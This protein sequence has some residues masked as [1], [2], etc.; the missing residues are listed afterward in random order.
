NQVEVTLTAEH[1]VITLYEQDPNGGLTYTV[2]DGTED[3]AMT[4]S[5]KLSDINRA[6]QWVIF[7]P[8]G[9]YVG[10]EASLTITTNDKGYLGTGG[11]KED[12]DTIPIHVTGIEGFEASPTWTTFPGA[13]DAS[14]DD[15]GMQLLSVSGGTDFIEKMLPTE[16]GKILAVGSVNSRFGILRFNSDLTLDTSFG[17]EGVVQSDLGSGHYAFDI[18]PHPEGGWL[19]AGNH[20]IARYTDEFNLDESFGPDGTGWTSNYDGNSV[21]DHSMVI[22]ADGKLWL[23]GQRGANMRLYRYSLDGAYEGQWDKHGNDS[24]SRHM[25]IRAN[26]DGTIVSVW[27]HAHWRGFYSEILDT[28]N[29]YQWT[30][31]NILDIGD[32]QY[33]DSALN[34]PDGKL[35]ITGMANGDAFVARY[36]HR[37]DLDSS[38]GESGRL[39]IPVLNSGDR[40]LAASLQPDGKILLVGRS[41][42][43]NNEDIFLVR[44]SYDG[45]LDDSLDGDGK[46]HLP[47]SGDD[48][49]GSAVLSL[50]D[51]KILIAGQSND[52]IALVRLYG[53]SNQDAAT[54]NLAPVNSVPLEVQ[55]TEVNKSLAFTSFRENLIST[56]DADA[57]ENQ[58]E[59][60]LTAEHGVITL[61]E[62]DPNGGL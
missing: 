40:A 48:D 6:L 47:F 59:V 18:I 26:D 11:A 7:H 9:D 60:T 29:G 46:V 33:A 2:G 15:D 58:V 20:R 50:P 38:F 34:L 41:H 10:N 45:V 31:V 19:V 8:E 53:D 3:G 39:Q 25:G 23:A 13:L 5:G 4:F 36:T 1:G 61:Y 12:T 30:T 17:T 62:Q 37:G 35:L 56:S 54:A 32:D 44:M 27:S 42:N 55:T 57:G 51:G 14:F 16:D 22:S 52:D 21:D 28:R 24:T 43:G 49:K